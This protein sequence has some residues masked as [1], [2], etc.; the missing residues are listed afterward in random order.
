MAPDSIPVS[1]PVWTGR[2]QEFSP[3]RKSIKTN[4]NYQKNWPCANRTAG[5][6]HVADDNVPAKNFLRFRCKKSSR[7]IRPAAGTKWNQHVDRT[8]RLLHR[9]GSGTQQQ[10][11]YAYK[12]SETFGTYKDGL[13]ARH[14]A[15]FRSVSRVTGVASA[16]APRRADTPVPEVKMF[17]AAF[18]SA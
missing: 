18:R 1:A 16:N 8:F 14:A 4:E 13:T 11:K 17:R 5:S 7:H 9:R 6:L 3:P 2:R 15:S 12:C 10:A